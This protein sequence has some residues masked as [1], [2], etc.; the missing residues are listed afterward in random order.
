MFCVQGYSQ[1][2]DQPHTPY[3]EDGWL[4]CQMQDNPNEIRPVSHWIMY[5]LGWEY[6]LDSS[7][8]WNYNSWGINDRGMKDV[9]IDY[10]LDGQNWMLLDTFEFEMASGS[11]K[12][13]GFEG[14]DF[15]GVA[16]RYVLLTA[17]NNW[18]N[19]PCT[20]LSE[21]KIYIGE[22]TT[23]VDP[24]LEINTVGITVVPNPVQ[25]KAEIS[26][27]SEA[28]PE[29]VALYDISGKVLQT[30]S[31]LNSKNVTMDLSGLPGGVYFV[32]AWVD[33]GLASTKLVKVN[34]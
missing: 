10:S 26:I 18:G 31:N 3:Y 28:I 2:L 20:G 17:L 33:D 7:Y 8:I 25:N 32:K 4:S 6:T 29:R 1:C 24:E 14:P 15:G 9:I 30:K 23:S 13:E 34:N 19:E 11:V 5:D 21:L 27:L 12:Y 22:P 16:A